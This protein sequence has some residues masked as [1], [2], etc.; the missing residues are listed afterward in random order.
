LEAMKMENEIRAGADGTVKELP[1]AVG[2][3]V[4][5]GAVLVVVE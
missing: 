3:K 4:P 1:V 5:D 2:D